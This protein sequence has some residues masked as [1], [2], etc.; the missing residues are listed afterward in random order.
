MVKNMDKTEYIDDIK[1]KLDHSY[2]NFLCALK[3]Y[4]E[5]SSF[6]IEKIET[7]AKYRKLQKC[8]P[9]LKDFSFVRPSSFKP[10]W[11]MSLEPSL[12][13]QKEGRDKGYFWMDV[14][15]Y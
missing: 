6:P 13:W 12:N 7:S 2:W 10:K 1:K 8:F 15:L 9:C 5:V 14:V 3:K 4:Y 11:F